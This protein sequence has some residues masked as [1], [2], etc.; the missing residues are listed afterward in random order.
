MVR[1]AAFVQTSYAMQTH[2]LVEPFSCAFVNLAIG[3]FGGEINGVPAVGWPI[4]WKNDYR[5]WQGKKRCSALPA[6]R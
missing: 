4:D 6:I 2:S 5:D 3:G 1:L